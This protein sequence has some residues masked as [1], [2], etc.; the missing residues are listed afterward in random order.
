MF[1]SGIIV[2]FIYTTSLSL[3]KKF[4]VKINN[5]IFLVP[6]IRALTILTIILNPYF[7]SRELSPN[8]F[9]LIFNNNFLIVLLFITIYLLLILIAAV[10]LT[11]LHEGPLK[12]QCY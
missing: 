3:S 9:F 5:L 6:V 11:E 10:K 1:I 12:S 2:V 8:L 7:L 4:L